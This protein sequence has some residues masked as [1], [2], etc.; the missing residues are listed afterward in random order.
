MPGLCARVQ[1]DEHSRGLGAQT[2]LGRREKAQLLKRGDFRLRQGGWMPHNSLPYPKVRPR[3]QAVLGRPDLL[4]QCTPLA[5][6]D[7]TPPRAPS[8]LLE[9][10]AQIWVLHPIPAPQSPSSSWSSQM[11]A[12]QTLPGP[13]RAAQL[14]SPLP[15]GGAIQFRPAPGRPPLTGLRREAGGA[16]WGGGGC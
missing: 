2:R 12:V 16:G 14:R 9:Q 7:P 11:P 5:H 1:R 4:K 15:R 8:F 10:R 6:L 13:P 3:G